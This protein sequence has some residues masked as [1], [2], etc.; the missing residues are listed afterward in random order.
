MATVAFE[1]WDRHGGPAGRAGDEISL[2]ARIVEVAYAAELFRGRQGGGG[3][4]AELRARAGGQLDPS[5]VEIFLT[6]AS[7]RFETTADPERSVW[8]QLCDAEPAPHARI[9]DAQLD[10]AALAFARFSD[11]KSAWFTGHSEHVAEIAE[12]AALELGLDI[13]ARTAVRRAGLLHAC[14]RRPGP[15]A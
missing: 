8:Q 6:N 9:S 7:H 4:E 15:Q 14:H 1:R 10:D 11:L 13:G 2:V 3:A 12:R 5:L